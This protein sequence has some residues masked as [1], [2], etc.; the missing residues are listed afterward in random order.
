MAQNEATFGLILT[1]AGNVMQ[2]CP[3]SAVADED[4][5]PEHSMEINIIFPH[6]L[7]ELNVFL[8]EPPFLPL[9]SVACSH[10]GV[11]KGSI[12]LRKHKMGSRTGISNL[13]IPRRLKLLITHRDLVRDTFRMRWPH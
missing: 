6:E 11:T 12:E 8:I 9:C 1:G 2:F 5:W 10:T 3:I 4:T 13:N 7:V